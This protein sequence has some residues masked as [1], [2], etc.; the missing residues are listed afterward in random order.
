[1]PEKKQIVSLLPRKRRFYLSLSFFRCKTEKVM[2][3]GNICGTTM[4]CLPPKNRDIRQITI[5]PESTI[6]AW[7]FRAESCKISLIYQ[8]FLRLAK[9]YVTSFINSKTHHFVH[10]VTSSNQWYVRINRGHFFHFNHINNGGHLSEV[11]LSKN[12]GFHVC[13]F[14]SNLNPL[15]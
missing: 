15:R 1:M 6:D 7:C 14:T 4:V 13:G 3:L 2:L 5:W 10:L 11:R 9:L 8:T 12:Q